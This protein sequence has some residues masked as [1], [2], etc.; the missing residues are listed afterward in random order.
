VLGASLAEAYHSKRSGLPAGATVSPSSIFLPFAGMLLLTLV[1]WIWMFRQRVL[2]M[3]ATGIEPKVRADLDQL[4]P[5]AVNSSANF[6][7]LF[8]LPVV[9]YAVVLA[10]HQL[11]LVD[12]LHV[13]CAF[14]FFVFRVVHS[15]IHCTYN[16]VMHR[17]TVY[18]IASGF[19][20]VMVLR[21]AWAV[22]VS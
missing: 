13:V 6:Q 19:L 8:E 7:N 5:R 16:H 18:A 3:R 12:A 10:L 11:A 4:G 1:V 21:L 14:G 2:G 17:F 20:W 15:I 22:L 9:F